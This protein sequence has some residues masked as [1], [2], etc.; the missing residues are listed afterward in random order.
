VRV[1]T[2][3]LLACWLASS[4]TPGSAA[5]V[6][7]GQP[8]APQVSLSLH[9]ALSIALANNL[10]YQSALADERI[11]EAR[12]VQAHSS[13]QP[14][15]SAGYSYVHTQTAESFLF[16]TP[17]GFQRIVVSG[18][19]INNVNATL[20]YAIYTGG[21]NVAAVG[22][23][24]AS[25]AASQ[26]NLAALRATIIRD[27]TSAYFTLLQA[28][29]AAAVADQ[30]VAVAEANLKTA[31]DLYAAG[32]SA[33]VDVLRTEVSLANARVAAIQA[34]NQAALANA[35]LANLL[36]INLNSQ[37]TPTDR[38]EA[39]TPSYTL[40][41]VLTDA[42][43]RPEV[44]AAQDAV[45]IAAEAVK[46]ARAGHLPTV[47]LQIQEASSKPNFF[48]VP[49]PQLTETLAA[50]WRIFDGGLTRGKVQE[51]QAQVD[52]ATLALHGLRNAVDL[53]AREAYL[54][55]EAALAQLDAARSARQ[56]A[57]E[58]YRV[59]AIRFKAGVGTSLELADA[60]LANTQAQDQYISALADLRISLVALQRAAGLLTGT[61]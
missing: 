27:T 6:A 35:Q 12:V 28:Q 36:D 40:Q 44:A 14:S 15:L 25:L 32:T 49:Q 21:A 56:A 53:E 41:E 60:L 13:L 23:A 52:K 7:P 42:A 38:L 45:T 26:A 1:F 57:Q 30:A 50:T 3:L 55:Y 19:D 20:E 2:L 4:A 24:A 8:P 31:N 43:A 47:S 51:A 58:S 39:Q 17:R 22:Q 37:I 29:R 11:A 54:N 16:P 18:T 61:P 10:Q 9:D 34:H 5:G 59:N 48:N 33:K 46:E